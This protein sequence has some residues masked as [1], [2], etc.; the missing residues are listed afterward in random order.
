MK[1]NTLLAILQQ[2][3]Y[4]W[5]SFDSW[6]LAHRQDSPK[7]DPQD[8]TLK[9]RIIKLISLSLFVIP[10]PARIRVALTIV[11]VLE[12]PIKFLLVFTAII[13]LRWLQK[14]GLITIAIAGSYGKTSTKHIMSWVLKK[15]IHLII[16]P[17]SVNTPL[18]I[19]QVILQ[20]LSSKHRLFVVEL[21]EYYCGDIKKLIKFLQ[22]KFGI[23]TPI[24]NQHLERMGS[25]KN[26]AATMSEL[27]DYFKTDKDKV[28]IA[29]QNKKFYHHD[30]NYYGTSSSCD[31]RVKK[32]SVTRKGTDF[33]I[34]T[35]Q[36][37]LESFSPLYGTHHVA[38][39]LPSLWL[40]DKLKLNVR[41][42]IQEATTL[43]C[44]SRRHEPIFGEH[45]VLILDNSY[46]T[47]PDSIKASLDLVNKLEASNRIIITLGF[48]ELGKKSSKL[49]YELGRL[50]AKKVDYVG[51]IKSRWNDQVKIGYL[52][53]GGI[54]SQFITASNPNEA[55]NLLHDKIKPNSIILIEGGYQEIF[56]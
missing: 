54:E 11:N 40:A 24:G 38:N 44:I 20:K 18:G 43:P 48:L 2:S 19:S 8:W 7:I 22:P 6:F 56:T 31:Y 25:L 36:L 33:V 42:T 13:K 21:G 14:Q 28:A 34:K 35:P 9:L 47:N 51:L 4:H 10:L 55:L 15:Q 37:E 16:T 12:S 30:W 46:N 29:D 50:L 53:A 39:L 1:I 41:K 5:D 32:A 45:S 52:E 27:L 49:H 3:E 17:K 26:I 23:L